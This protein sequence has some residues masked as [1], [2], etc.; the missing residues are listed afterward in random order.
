MGSFISCF[1]PCFFP[2]GEDL[3]TQTLY[4]TSHEEIRY[5]ED[6]NFLGVP[7]YSILYSWD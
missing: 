6:D 2:S 3:S 5:V 4:Q 7:I 1:I